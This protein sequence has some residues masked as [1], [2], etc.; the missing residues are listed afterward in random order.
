MITLVRMLIHRSFE[1]RFDRAAG[2]NAE[3]GAAGHNLIPEY[4]RHAAGYSLGP[5]PAQYSK[6]PYPLKYSWR[7]PGLLSALAVS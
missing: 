5:G 3:R 2:E 4:D 7:G 6:V 1:S